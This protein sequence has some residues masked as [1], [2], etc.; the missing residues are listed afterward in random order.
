MVVKSADGGGNLTTATVCLATHSH[1]GF[2]H[3]EL[4]DVLEGPQSQL[5]QRGSSAESCRL[6][7]QF[8]ASGTL[9]TGNVSRRELPPY[10][11]LLYRPGPASSMEHPPLILSPAIDGTSVSYLADTLTD[12]SLPHSQLFVTASAS[13]T[14]PVG[15]SMAS[16]THSVD[17][18]WLQVLSHILHTSSSDGNKGAGYVPNSSTVSDTHPS[19]GCP[20]LRP[21]PVITTPT[22]GL[23]LMET[24]RD[25]M[26]AAT[27]ISL[28]RQEGQ[29]T[30]PVGRDEAVVSPPVSGQLDDHSHPEFIQTSVKDNPKMKPNMN[31]REEENQA[32]NPYETNAT[33]GQVTRHGTSRL[34]KLNLPTLTNSPVSCHEG[35]G[36]PL[37]ESHNLKER[38]RRARIK[39]ACN[40]MRQLVPGMSHKTDKATVF[41][42]SARYI[43]FLK[44]F[45][46]S[47]NDK[48]FL[49]KY[50]PY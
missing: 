43:H 20:I 22:G 46:G 34:S 2:Q 41:E 14:P 24:S 30:A 7:D 15:G 17:P 50:S 31:S 21:Y 16:S 11:L 5:P 33:T 32:V 37:R 12:R 48:E 9:M 25:K 35:S 40:L 1:D 8:Q 6:E 23:D 42:F 45:V 19:T 13:I 47:N 18:A 38:R 29:L 28:T 4:S 44:S 3:S 26:E 10:S 49:V 27:S 36:G 39:D